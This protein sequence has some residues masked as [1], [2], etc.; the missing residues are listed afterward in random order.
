MSSQRYERVRVSP[1]CSLFQITALSLRLAYTDI[2]Y[3]QVSPNDQD[4]TPISPATPLYDAPHTPSS[5]PPS[6]RSRP[7]SP[8]SR[9]LLSTHDPLA[10]DAERT[11]ND[12]F[13]DGSDSENENTVDDR[14]RLMRS[15]TNHSVQEQGNNGDRP[16]AFRATTAASIPP[17]PAALGAA[18]MVPTRRPA[19]FNQ[20]QHDGVFANLDAKPEKGEKLEELPPVR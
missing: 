3:L 2:F 1:L 12:T 10:T 5:P 18:L 19:S 8:S 16:T 9:H 13:D 4:D 15:N 6:F 14:Q 11:L 7:S 17:T 20:S